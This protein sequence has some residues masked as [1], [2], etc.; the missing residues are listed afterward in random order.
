MGDIWQINFW[1]QCRTSK[2]RLHKLSYIG[3]YYVHRERCWRW[4]VVFGDFFIFTF[5]SSSRQQVAFLPLSNLPKVFFFSFGL[6]PEERP[7]GPGIDE[8][9]RHS[10]RSSRL[11]ADDGK[12]RPDSLVA[13][14]P[15]AHLHLD[16][17]ENPSNSAAAAAAI[18]EKTTKTYRVYWAIT[19]KRKS[20][21]KR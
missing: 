14:L 1:E 5:A 13:W 2:W 9:R 16:E 21:N 20:K 12:T 17:P 7:E 6:T 3:I 19:E 8:S 15:A 18:K 11:G 10:R 4:F